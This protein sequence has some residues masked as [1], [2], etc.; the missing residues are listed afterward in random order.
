MRVLPRR[1]LWSLVLI[2]CLV[3]ILGALAALQYRWVG[4][5][6]EDRRVILRTRL[7]NSVEI[8]RRA[9]TFE[10]LELGTDFRREPRPGGFSDDYETELAQ[11][12]VRWKRTSPHP[13]LARDLYV[14]TRGSRG[15]VS[16]R[17]F[18]EARGEFVPAEA[19]P[20]LRRVIEACGVPSPPARTATEG[21]WIFPPGQFV[22][23]GRQ[24]FL[25]RPVPAW[26][27]GRPDSLGP[28]GLLILQ[29]DAGFMRQ[30]LVPELIERAFGDDA[31]AAYDIAIVQVGAAGQ[32]VPIYGPQAS[33]QEGGPPDIRTSVLL[34]RGPVPAERSDSAAAGRPGAPVRPGALVASCAEAERW[35]L[36][37]RHRSGSLAEEVKRY[38]FRN[39]AISAAVLFLLSS[40]IVL[41]ILSTQRAQRLAKLQMDFTAGVSHELRTPLTIIRSAAD[42]LADGAVADPATVQEYGQ[43]IQRESRRL[44]ALLEETLEFAAAQSGRRRLELALI[45]VSVVIKDALRQTEAL[46]QE[47]GMSVEESLEAGLPKVWADATVLSRCIQNLITNAV[48]YGAEGRWIG[49]RAVN[50]RNPSQPFVLI[51]VMDKGPGVKPEDLPMIFSPFYQGKSKGG[52]K[53]AGVGLGLSLTKEM[54]KAL[55]GA[56]SVESEPGQGARFTL[57]VP[58]SQ[59]DEKAGLV[60]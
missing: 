53:G 57:H 6:S 45:E 44:T 16:L 21:R 17:R 11:R 27:F 8:F 37:V 34:D 3:A 5:L 39:L 2:L 31:Q 55:G 14:Q 26:P 33:F 18:D 59:A 48:K 43:L 9:F 10:L 41:L 46:W 15:L 29:L 60:G 1:T 52:V 36:W 24:A 38:H 7:E 13:E 23:L 4:Q 51:S 22:A 12:Y 20:Q 35:E 28:P 19:S 40:S 47:A 56:I 54:M 30:T 32:A 50:D 42:N 58:R 25:L 49:I